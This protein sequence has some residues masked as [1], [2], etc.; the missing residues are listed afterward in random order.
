MYFGVGILETEEL[1]FEP[2]AKAGRVW[3]VP[4]SQPR[5]NGP[6]S[7]QVIRFNMCSSMICSI[8]QQ[9]KFQPVICSL[10]ANNLLYSTCVSTAHIFFTIVLV[11]D[12]HCISMAGRSRPCERQLRR[13]GIPYSCRCPWSCTGYH[14]DGSGQ[15][16]VM[17]D[18]KTDHGVPF[19]T[20]SQKYTLVVNAARHDEQVSE[21]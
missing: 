14:V 3:R 1:L 19:W 6:M 7:G 2:T 21:S 16:R 20:C 13:G 5:D 18:V 4:G 10:S 15:R 8:K 11:R 12:D 17:L 9:L